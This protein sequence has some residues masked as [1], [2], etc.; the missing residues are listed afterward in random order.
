MRLHRQRPR[1]T[2]FWLAAL[3]GAG[4]VLASG[5]AHALCI[6]CN[7][8]ITSTAISFG[9]YDTLGSSPLASTGTLGF[10]CVT[11]VS[12]GGINFTVALNTGSSGTFVTRT[13]KNGANT[14]NYNLYTSVTD[15]TVWGDGTAGTATVSGTYPMSNAPPVTLTVYGLI[16]AQQNVLAGSYSDSITATVTF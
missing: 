6:L 4:L 7:C 12:L 11:G 13:L 3:G 16:P 5:V 2:K 10:S 1:R 9:N 8:T 14:L 15:T